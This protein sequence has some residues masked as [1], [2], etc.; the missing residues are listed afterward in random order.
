MKAS[1]LVAIVSSAVFL[2]ASAAH[3]E[4]NLKNNSHNQNFLSKRPY[5]QPITKS[6]QK[7][8]QQWEGA[9]LIDEG[10]ETDDKHKSMRL[11]M[12]GK[13]PYVER[14]TD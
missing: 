3:A 4:S 7:K 10:A 5:E 13:R 8:D 9:T 12:L 14:N 2:V 1:N 11:H 6:D